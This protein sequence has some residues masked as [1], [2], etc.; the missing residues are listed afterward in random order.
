MYVKPNEEHK[1]SKKYPNLYGVETGVALTSL[2][3]H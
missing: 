1:L 3:S 2:H